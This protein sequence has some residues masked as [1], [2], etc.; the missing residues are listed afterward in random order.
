LHR[1]G[2]SRP[3]PSAAL[4]KRMIRRLYDWV[5]S[6]AE[7]RYGTHALFVLAFAESSFFPIP[8]DV[9]L[10]GLALGRPERAYRFALVCTVGSVAGGAFGYLIGWQLMETVGIPILKLY[11]AME[12]F[13][14]V[15]AD[16]VKYGGWA[17]AIAAFTPI[18]YKV[19]TIASGAVTLSFGTFIAASVIGRAGRFYL[20]AALIFFFGSPVKAFIDRHF[21]LLTVV[22]TALLIL[23]FLLIEW[24]R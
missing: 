17:V 21:N 7:S 11:H 13:E 4:R 8:P 12:K 5:L 20:V 18:P 6:W 1:I 22:F 2:R 23:G 10:I 9:L 3:A 15:R 14:A 16:F 19:F 24:L